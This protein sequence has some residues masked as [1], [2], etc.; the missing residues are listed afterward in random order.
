MTEIN[1]KNVTKG[2][3]TRP[4][5]DKYHSATVVV[6]AS[7]AAFIAS[8]LDEMILIGTGAIGIPVAVATSSWVAVLF[9]VVLPIVSFT[10]TFYIGRWL[11]RRVTGDN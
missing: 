6:I 2:C 3:S 4:R 11:L 8:P 5:K 9:W 10:I 7:F 1:C